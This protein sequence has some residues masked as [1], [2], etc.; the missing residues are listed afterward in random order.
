MSPRLLAIQ[1]IVA[2]LTARAAA[3]AL[4]GLAA[5]FAFGLPSLLVT[6]LKAETAPRPPSSLIAEIRWPDDCSSNVD[7]WVVGPLE[8]PASD[9][10]RAGAAF[11]DLLGSDRRTRVAQSDPNYKNTRTPGLA[12]GDYAVNLRLESHSGGC[13]L[14]IPVDVSVQLKEKEP[15]RLTVVHKGRTLLGRIGEETTAVRF[16]LRDGELISNSKNTLS[17]LRQTQ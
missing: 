15:K 12:D 16:S 4:A 5:A 9:S 17:L 2:H 8:K 10:N 6:P 7:L 14:P 13:S 1:V 11:F 3:L